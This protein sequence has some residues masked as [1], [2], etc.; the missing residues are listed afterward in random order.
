MLLGFSQLCSRVTQGH[1]H[2]HTHALLSQ[3]HID[4]C[5]PAAHT[6]TSGCQ[7]RVCFRGK[8]GNKSHGRRENMHGIL[9]N[10]KV[11]DHTTLAAS[12]LPS[13][14]ACTSVSVWIRYCKMTALFSGVTQSLAEVE[15]P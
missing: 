6:V 13:L 11:Q 4:N 14:Y 12:F 2:T 5:R 1:T 15:G 7:S 3:A 9:E 8:K 10:E